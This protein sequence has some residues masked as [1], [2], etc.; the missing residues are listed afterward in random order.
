MSPYQHYQ[1]DF[2]SDMSF[3]PEYAPDTSDEEE[4]EMEVGF[5]Q[6]K[7]LSAGLPAVKTEAERDD[8]RLR[9]LQERQ[10]EADSDD[11]LEDR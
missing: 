10:R 4:E 2:E 5:K 8:R 9:R 6:K 3:R 1:L 7:S 11:E